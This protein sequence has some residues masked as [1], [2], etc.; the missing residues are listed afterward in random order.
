MP[1]NRQMQKNIKSN[2]VGRL[3]PEKP[4][5]VWVTTHKV[6]KKFDFAYCLSNGMDGMIFPDETQIVGDPNGYHFWYLDEKE[7]WT[8]HTKPHKDI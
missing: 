8:Q 2:K 7:E 4:S 3:E 6:H 1:T 5:E